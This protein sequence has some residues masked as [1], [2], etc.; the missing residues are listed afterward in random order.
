MTLCGSYAGLV[1][2]DRE[3]RKKCRK[4]NIQGLW[5]E[6]RSFKYRVTHSAYFFFHIARKILLFSIDL[7]FDLFLCRHGMIACSDV[8][9]L[10]K[11][12]LWKHSRGDKELE[13][14]F[15]ALSRGNRGDLES[16]C[17]SSCTIICTPRHVFTFDCYEFFVIIEIRAISKTNEQHY[18]SLWSSNFSLTVYKSDF[19]VRKQ[20]VI[21]RVSYFY[22]VNTDR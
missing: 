19:S 22:L 16:S 1:S 13:N 12:L 2:N 4:R 5:A 17:D 9:G 10:R 11:S 3:K 21:S 20:T 7:Y 8:V 18:F 14:V 6:Q 15:Q